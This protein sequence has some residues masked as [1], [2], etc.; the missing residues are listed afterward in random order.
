MHNIGRLNENK[1]Q[2]PYFTLLTTKSGQVN[3]KEFVK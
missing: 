3:A 1:S 2:I